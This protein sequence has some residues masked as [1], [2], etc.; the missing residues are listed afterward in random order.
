MGVSRSAPLPLRRHS[1]ATAWCCFPQSRIACTEGRHRGRSTTAAGPIRAPSPCEPLLSERFLTRRTA[2]DPLSPAAP[3]PGPAVP[4]PPTIAARTTL[5]PAARHPPRHGSRGLS[6]GVAAVQCGSAPSRAPIWRTAP[7]SGRSG[8]GCVGQPRPA[9]P[10][11]GARPP[12]PQLLSTTAEADGV[13]KA[14]C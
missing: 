3:P 12:T 11:S 1:T 7:P 9:A 8:E 14:T 6:Q 10:V 5:R 13:S 4:D 2:R